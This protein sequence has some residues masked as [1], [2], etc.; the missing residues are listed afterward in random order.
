MY[1][2]LEATPKEIAV[3]YIVVISACL[4][5]YPITHLVI[6]AVKGIKR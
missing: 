5:I 6:N 2:V 1:E 3:V 4:L